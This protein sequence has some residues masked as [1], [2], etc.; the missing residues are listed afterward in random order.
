MANA[1]FGCQVDGVTISEYQANFANEQAVSRGRRRPGAVPP[2]EHARHRL[3]RRGVPGHLDERD[4]DVRRPV[5]P[6]QRVRPPPVQAADGTCASPAVTTTSWEASLRRS[7]RSTTITSATSIPGA[8]TSKPLQPTAWYPSRCIDLTPQ[9]IPY[10]ELR[11]ESSVAYRDRG[12]V[13]LVLSRW[14][15]PVP[16]DRG[17]P[18][19]TSHPAA[20]RPFRCSGRCRHPS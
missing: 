8:P 10:W 14:Q 1:R 2:A 15:L 5:R 20:P 11:A 6:L 12:G 19:V 18:G 9:A 13:S 17:R 4:D 7:P 3:S 16:P